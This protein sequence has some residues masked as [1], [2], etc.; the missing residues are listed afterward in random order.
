MSQYFLLLP[1]FFVCYT[2]IFTNLVAQAGTMQLGSTRNDLMQSLEII[3]MLT[4]IP[5]LDRM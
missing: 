5:V 4:L 1:F 3:F 2:Q